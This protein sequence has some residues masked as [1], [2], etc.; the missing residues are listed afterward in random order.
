MD[1]CSHLSHQFGLLRLEAQ[2]A[3]FKNIM[4]QGLLAIDGFVLIHGR[5]GCRSMC[6]IGCCNIDRVDLVGHRIEHFSKV[7]KK[8]SIGMLFSGCC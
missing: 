1:L 6:M 5:H 2:H 4:R 8:L 7:S 3:G